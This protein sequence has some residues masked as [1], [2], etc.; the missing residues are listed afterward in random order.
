MT[1]RVAPRR[2]VLT[3]VVLY[4]LVVL[5]A[6][7]VFASFLWIAPRAPLR[8]VVPGTAL[9]SYML[10]LFGQSWSVFAPEPINGDYRLDVR[11]VADGET[12]DW[13]SATDVEVSMIRSTLTPPRGGIQAID[14][15]SRFKGAWDKL[16]EAG[17]EVAAL[18]YYKD[19]W[20]T[21]MAAELEGHATEDEVA[22]YLAQ[23]RRTTAY[24]SQVAYAIWGDGVEQVQFRSSRQNIIPFAERN[25]PD[26]VRPEAQNA[27]TGWRGPVVEEG[28]SSDSFRDVFLRAYERLE[29]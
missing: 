16:D 8:E 12:T 5:T 7:H 3:R 1:E 10:P 18:N 9:S 11:A 17:K 15:S 2:S 14:V 25:D 19:D 6:W 23:E 27:A 29:K 26:A 22:A 13:V 4:A 21:R 28:Q 20:E 24:A